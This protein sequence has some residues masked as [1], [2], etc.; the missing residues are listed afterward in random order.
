MLL[1]NTNRKSMWEVKLHHRFDLAGNVKVMATQILKACIWQ[2]SQLLLLNTTRKSCMG[3]PTATLD[4]TLID[5][6]WSI[7]RK[8]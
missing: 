2:K 1:L 3:S 4:V 6:E 8:V 5:L 7:S